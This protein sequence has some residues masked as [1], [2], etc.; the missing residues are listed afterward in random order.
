MKDD[1]A[2][3]KC[4]CAQHVVAVVVTKGK[5]IIFLGVVTNVS[6]CRGVRIVLVLI[7]SYCSQSL[8]LQPL[9]CF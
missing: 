5:Q 8:L 1:D 3:R 2:G 9:Y 4:I 7:V 6:C